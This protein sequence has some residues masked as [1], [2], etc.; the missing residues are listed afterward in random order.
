MQNNECVFVCEQYTEYQENALAP[1]TKSR[2]ENHLSLCAPCS[3]L[4]KSLDNLLSNL[5]S[6]PAPST[7]PDFTKTLMARIETLNQETLWHKVYTS[8]YTRVAGYAIA[9]GLVVALGLNV[10][11]DP[12]S[13]VNPSGVRSFTVEQPASESSSTE[14][15]VILEDSV[16]SNTSDTL[17]LQKNTI[18]GSTQSMQL[19]NDSR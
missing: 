11:L 5:H 8:S 9:A 16:V 18:D 12:V 2:V 10:W 1:E 13:T 3:D 7:K 6:L 15:L 19:V 17:Q 14:G 4:F